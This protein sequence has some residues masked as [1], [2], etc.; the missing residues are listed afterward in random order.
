M[1]AKFLKLKSKNSLTR[2]HGLLFSENPYVFTKI[3]KYL[4]KTFVKSGE[5]PQ[6]LR[7]Y[8][9]LPLFSN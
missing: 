2:G 8:L 6:P 1:N 7:H 9:K 5:E 3:A 4:Q